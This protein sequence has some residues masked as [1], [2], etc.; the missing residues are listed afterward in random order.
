MAKRRIAIFLSVDDKVTDEPS[1]TRRIDE[2]EN[3]FPGADETYKVYIH[4]D[5]QREKMFPNVPA[6]EAMLTTAAHEF[7]H[8]LSSIFKIPGG[9]HEDPRQHGEIRGCCTA[10][11]ATPEQ[12]ER[13]N[14]NE[15]LAWE[16]GRKI[17][18]NLNE[19][20]AKEALDTY[21]VAPREVEEKMPREKI[22][23]LLAGIDD[24]IA[25]LEENEKAKEAVKTLQ[26]A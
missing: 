12:K 11:V 3:Q 4:G 18:P 26:P 9:M 16:I 6:N 24:L 1:G 5:D 17:V 20:M 23:E 19:D 8:V 22:L 25:D 14:R 13:I 15:T 10:H 21:L 2:K 7:G